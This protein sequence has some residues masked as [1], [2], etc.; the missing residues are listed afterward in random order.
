M[1]D[2]EYVIW[3]LLHEKKFEIDLRPPRHPINATEVVLRCWLDGEVYS[4]G[5]FHLI[6]EQKL[7]EFILMQAMR[8][9]ADLKE[10]GLK[11]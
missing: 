10:K 9:E 8:F 4:R 11:P 5:S 2:L 1:N 3:F 7:H 6:K